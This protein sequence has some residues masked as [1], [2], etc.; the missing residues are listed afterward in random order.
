MKKFFEGFKKFIT[1]GNVID[2][3]VGVIIAAAFSAIVNALV[4]KVIMPFISLFTGGI[5]LAKMSVVLNGVPMYMEDGVTINPSAIVLYYGEVIQSIINFLIIAFVLYSVLKAI[6]GAQ[7]LL[8]PKFG[9]LTKT[10]YISLRK[11]GKSKKEVEAIG[12]A[13]AAEE[14]AKKDAEEA[15]KARHTTTALLEDIKRLLEEQKTDK[16]L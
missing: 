7:G 1:R 8:T 4:N 16:P 11:S 10:E 3:A 9:G 6:M 2:M 5:S 15:E 14:K 13:R 12:V